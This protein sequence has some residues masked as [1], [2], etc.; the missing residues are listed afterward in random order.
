M[1]IIDV[2]VCLF[3]WCADDLDFFH[4]SNSA[5]SRFMGTWKWTL[6]DS[7]VLGEVDKGSEAV[8]H[9][10][11]LGHKFV[12]KTMLRVMGVLSQFHACPEINWIN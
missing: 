2:N 3:A 4:R 9:A 6:D 11:L 5:S 8:K 10:E 7:D 1:F 12:D